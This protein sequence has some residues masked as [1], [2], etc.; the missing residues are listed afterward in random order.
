MALKGIAE[1]P[2]HYG[3]MPAWLYAK[4]VELASAI[5]KII[6]YE[7]GES[8]ILKRLSNPFWFQALGCVLG[9]DWHSSGLTTTLTASLRDAF[10]KAEIGLYVAGGKGKTSK[11]TPQHIKNYCQSLNMPEWKVNKLVASSKLI[12]KIDN[13]V[14]QDSYELYHHVL[15]FDD[16]ARYAVV[17]QGMNIFSK[18]ARRYHWLSEKIDEQGFFNDSHSGIIT[19][20]RLARVIDLSSKKSHDSRKEILDLAKEN[21]SRI[22]RLVEQLKLPSAQLTLQKWLKQE[23]TEKEIIQKENKEKIKRLIMQSEHEIFSMPKRINYRAFKKAYEQ[24]PSSFEAL[25]GIEGMG[26]ANLRALALISSLIYGKEPSW[27]DPASYSFAHG[28]K[29]GVPY[30]VN[31][32]RYEKSIVM[33]SDAIKNAELGKR[34]K[35]DALKRLERFIT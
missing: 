13:A 26:K 22:R 4:M 10:R 9:F 12:A 30:P 29:D 7:Y 28:G 31:K 14:L 18:Y 2:L 34:D 1:L 3:K 24:E 17:Q 5:S 11:K 20:F 35:L 6:A 16:K 19:A 32:L 25:L 27:K 33:L 15:I 23:P 21:P 8:E